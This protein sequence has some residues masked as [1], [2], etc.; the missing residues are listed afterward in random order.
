MIHDPIG[1]KTNP[2][3][4]TLYSVDGCKKIG[5]EMIIINNKKIKDT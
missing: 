5:G 3:P 1:K 2:R 4:T